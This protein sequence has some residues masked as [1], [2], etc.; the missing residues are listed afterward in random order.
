MVLLVK[1]YIMFGLFVCREFLHSAVMRDSEVELR[2][3][4]DALQ[5]ISIIIIIIACF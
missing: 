2:L 4:N 3:E 1:M 5:K